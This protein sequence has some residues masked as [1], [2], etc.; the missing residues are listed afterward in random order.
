MWEAEIGRAVVPGQPRQKVHK[1]Q[2]QQNIN[3]GIVLCA[4]HPNYDG[5]FKNRNILTQVGLGKK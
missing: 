3:R 4:C 5:K 2:S 1:T